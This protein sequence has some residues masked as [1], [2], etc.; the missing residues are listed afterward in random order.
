[1]WSFVGKKSNKAW[2]WLAIDR[3][4]RQIVG[5]YIG[6]R[7]RDDALKLWESLPGVYRQCAVCYTDFWESYKK[8]L[9]ACRHRAAGKETGMT[10]HIERTNCTLRQRV[11]RLVR[12]TLSFSK[13][14]ENHILSIKYFI[15]HFNLEVLSRTG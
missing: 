14:I 1:M 11:S 5:F 3:A 15:F 13:I 4:S 6:G 12:K 9:P 8:V 7:G 2:I 10:N